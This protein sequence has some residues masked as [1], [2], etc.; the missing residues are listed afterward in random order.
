MVLLFSLVTSIHRQLR[1]PCLKQCHR[2]KLYSQASADDI[3]SLNVAIVGGG[4]AGLAC[5]YHMQQMFLDSSSTT[6]HSRLNLSFFAREPEPIGTIV[7]TSCASAVSA[8]LLV[9]TYIFP[10]NPIL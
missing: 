4:Y 5:G 9:G 7:G 10:V 3:S 2:M 8:G 6:P 1:L